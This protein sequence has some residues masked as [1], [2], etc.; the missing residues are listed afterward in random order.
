[1]IGVI[2]CRVSTKEQVGGTSLAS[3]REA[4]LQYAASHGIKI[5][6]IFDEEGESAKFSDRTKLLSLIEHCRVQKNVQALIVWKVD[7]FARNVEDH[8]AI[9][10]E[11]AKYG[12]FIHSVT[13]PITTDPVGK[14][15]EVLLPAHA[16]FENEIR[17]D[18]A[19]RGM[20]RKVMEGLF[21]WKPPLGYLSALPAGQKKT[22]PDVP[23]PQR[24]RIIKEAW[25][26]VLSGTYQKADIFRFLM[27]RNMTTRTGKPVS[28]RIVDEIFRNKY[29][30][31]I[32]TDPWAQKDYVGKHEAIVTLEEFARVQEILRG[33][34]RSIPHI[35]EHSDFPLRGFVQCRGCAGPL[36][37]SWS[38]G[39]SKRYGYYCCFSKTCSRY[40]KS[41]PRK[42]LHEDF[43]SLLKR[44]S[45]NPRLLTLIRK[46]M[47]QHLDT[48]HVKDRSVI[49]K[50][51]TKVKE[52]ERENRELIQMRR[53]S[54]ISDDEFIREHESLTQSIQ[55]IQVTLAGIASA[56]EF[57]GTH[58]DL[59][60]GFLV[61]LFEKW[62]NI[63]THFQQRFQKIM[64][65]NGIVHEQFGTAKCSHIF[66]LI[67]DFKSEKQTGVR[68]SIRIWNQA[69]DDS[70]KL[71][72]L[73]QDLKAFQEAEKCLVQK[74][75]A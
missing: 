69:R 57:N 59:I 41:I 75:T 11:L 36:T 48:L 44:Y 25:R 9:K 20:Q 58:L 63:P 45:V 65:G 50:H 4:C 14:F 18:R 72:S 1:M 42:L 3:Q 29:Y 68:P 35:K 66:R 23:D 38:K 70:V 51:K 32:L 6:K 26:L 49:E 71:V 40:G 74:N 8:F 21:P 56:H 55:S 39:R 37:G 22:V 17:G 27:N 15:T 30:A 54:L 64:F 19:V 47:L 60:L 33:R 43:H 52:L 67:D 2:Y 46:R 12:T 73:I 62:P 16:Q 13:E 7:R 10:K 53:R 61:S 34:S 31:G 5:A 24:F 28:P